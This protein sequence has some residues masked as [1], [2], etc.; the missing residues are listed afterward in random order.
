M[1]Y[2]MFITQPTCSVL[3]TAIC[4]ETTQFAVM[5]FKIKVFN[6]T[7]KRHI[8][9]MD[10]IMVQIKDKWNVKTELPTQDV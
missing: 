3:L 10:I 9:F 5:N 1:E 2:G 4:F 7:V 8:T 6:P